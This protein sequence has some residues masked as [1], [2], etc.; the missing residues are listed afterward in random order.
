MAEPV[1]ASIRAAIRDAFGGLGSGPASLITDL[2]SGD[3]KP[4]RSPYEYI[5]GTALEPI[6]KEDVDTAARLSSSPSV[7]MGIERAGE[8]SLPSPAVGAAE[9]S[10]GIVRQG[11]DVVGAVP[12]TPEEEAERREKIDIAKS[13]T[14]MA[15][16]ER[17]AR[18][19][20]E[21]ERRSGR[22]ARYPSRLIVDPEADPFGDLDEAR[23]LDALRR[24][25]LRRAG[26]VDLLSEEANAGK[27]PSFLNP[28]A[29]RAEQ[30][31][32]PSKLIVGLEDN[33]PAVFDKI[34]E[35][36]KY[37]AEV[38][39]ALKRGMDAQLA[40]S[41]GRVVPPTAERAFSIMRA[42][43]GGERVGDKSQVPN[44]LVGALSQLTS[45]RKISS[46]N[47]IYTL[48][49]ASGELLRMGR[50]SLEE[51]SAK[52]EAYV[53]IGRKS[54]PDVRERDIA[55]LR[56]FKDVLSFDR[57]KRFYESSAARLQADLPVF[58][59]AAT[60]TAATSS[61]VAAPVQ[62]RPS[63]PPAPDEGWQRYMDGS[64][65][66]AAARG[67][68]LGAWRDR[69]A[70]IFANPEPEDFSFQNFVQWWKT[71]KRDGKFRDNN[72]GGY[73]EAIRILRYEADAT[74]AGMN[75]G[76]ARP[77]AAK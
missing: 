20:R 35:L 56:K 36:I 72:R 65:K 8:E 17:E 59:S 45:S 53:P 71:M 41:A 47:L 39:A 74:R 5:E 10:A 77:V 28:L 37:L 43:A 29:T 48:T 42:L 62:Q 13:E 54:P 19:A 57:I 66:D 6:R 31:E 12:L 76:A 30:Y 46:K 14:L 64:P 32:A 34:T 73:R 67:A 44:G 16:A 33:D 24:A 7:I 75:A 38:V 50:E 70:A 55:A 2:T 61:A 49:N 69:Q 4:R 21:A 63:A 58:S 26:R 15:Q 40:K 22:G 51:M 60:A 1:K 68:V 11:P 9:V 27:T 3:G 18:L 52:P 23:T 25:L